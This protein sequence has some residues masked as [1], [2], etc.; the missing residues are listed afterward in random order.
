MVLVMTLVN[1]VRQQAQSSESG[2]LGRFFFE[3]EGAKIDVL[4]IDLDGRLPPS[5]RRSGDS[6]VLRSAARATWF[7]VPVLRFGDGSQVVFTVVEFVPVDVIGDTLVVQT[8]DIAMHP[9]DGHFAVDADGSDSIA[10]LDP[11]RELSESLCVVQI[12]DG[13]RSYLA[14]SAMHNRDERGHAVITWDEDTGSSQML[15]AFRAEGVFRERGFMGRLQEG[16]PARRTR[17]LD[18]SSSLRDVVA[19]HQAVHA[20]TLTDI[21]RDDLEGGAAL[22]ANAR[23]SGTLSR[24]RVSPSLGARPRSLCNQR[25]GFVAPIIPDSIRSLR[26][27][28]RAELD[29]EWLS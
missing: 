11:P 10:P 24:H 19:R 16:R 27:M 2:N 20:A 25:R 26:V 22:P 3:A 14:G 28:A 15:A 13:V 12:N 6:P 5:S 18:R 7:V 9:D 4:A 1:G 23:D 8:E 21:G 17:P 29:A